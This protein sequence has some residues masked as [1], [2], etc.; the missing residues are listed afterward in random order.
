MYGVFWGSSLPSSSRTWVLFD[1]CLRGGVLIRPEWHSGRGGA[2]PYGRWSNGAR[3]LGELGGLFF[4]S[5]L[6]G[7]VSG[8]TITLF[9]TE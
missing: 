1:R 9:I 8:D 6:C 3:F 7:R 5:V 2:L 4:R